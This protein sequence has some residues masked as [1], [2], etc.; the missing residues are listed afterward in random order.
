MSAA[1]KSRKFSSQFV[2]SL[3]TPE[4]GFCSK[5][6]KNGFERDQD[7]DRVMRCA[8]CDTNHRLVTA[9][10]AYEGSEDD[11]DEDDMQGG[12]TAL[13]KEAHDSGDGQTIYHCPFCGSGSVIG[14]SDGTVECEYCENCFTVQVQPQFP[15]MPQTNPVTGE[16]LPQPGMPGQIDGP[17]DNALQP[18]EDEPKVGYPVQE[19]QPTVGGPVDSEPDP[20]NPEGPT[21]NDDMEKSSKLFVTATGYALPEDSFTKHLAIL[22]ADDREAVLQTIVAERAGS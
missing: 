3:P 8:S 11:C 21:G 5:C 10:D 16:P 15:N 12:V 2:A 20:L 6:G 9:A 19:D 22:Y 4:D 18:P 13:L 17:E 1:I 14:R 7:D